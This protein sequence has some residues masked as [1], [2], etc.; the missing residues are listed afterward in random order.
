[1]IGGE[2]FDRYGVSQGFAMGPADLACGGYGDADTDTRFGD[3][4]W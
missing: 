1:M 2:Q 3:G 4:K